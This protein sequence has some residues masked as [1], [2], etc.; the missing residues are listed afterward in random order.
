MS[1]IYFH[2]IDGE[3]EIWGAERAWAACLI[4]KI[5]LS[6]LNVEE[7]YELLRSIIHPTHYLA[8]IN[9][10]KFNDKY[11]AWK[12][13]ETAISV[14]YGERPLFILDNKPINEWRLMLN[15][16]MVVGS[17]PIRLFTR[18]HAQ[19]EIHAYIKGKNRKWL[20]EIILE[21]LNSKIYR[22]ESGWRKLIDFLNSDNKNTVV[23]SYSVCE[24][25]PHPYILG[26]SGDDAYERFDKLGK[27]VK[28][29]KCLKEL[30]KNKT[31]EISPEMLY[32]GFGNEMNAFELLN[33][34]RDKK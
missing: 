3:V 2:S 28:W 17:N 32:V 4:N 27:E 6:I 22:E 21:G 10:N 9:D 7:N 30:Y 16:A 33:T 12:A 8:N 13:I 31:L 18:L 23:T 29:K 1:R 34:L 26:L 19:C 5:G 11:P 25:F 14:G 15:T 24:Q 20:S